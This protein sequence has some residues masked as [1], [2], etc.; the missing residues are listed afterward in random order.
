MPATIA[1]IALV[2][3]EI[4]MIICPDCHGTGIEEAE[5]IPHLPKGD[6]AE[7]T[8]TTWQILPKG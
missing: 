1:A 5:S 8:E 7:V 2:A 6:P 3:G 4:Q